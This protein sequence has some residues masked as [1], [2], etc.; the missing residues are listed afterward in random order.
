MI[1]AESRMRVDILFS[2][3]NLQLWTCASQPVS[4]QRRRWSRC[5][6]GWG[7]GRVFVVVGPPGR[8]P[9]EDKPPV[10]D[11]GTVMGETGAVTTGGQVVQGV[12]PHALQLYSK[13]PCA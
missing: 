4:Q 8:A 7:V 2:I 9:L 1:M 11:R 12:D 3:G 10:Y 6:S 5:T 13:Y